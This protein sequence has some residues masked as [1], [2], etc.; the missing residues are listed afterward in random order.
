MIADFIAAESP[1]PPPS[2]SIIADYHL[3]YTEQFILYSHLRSFAKV[4]IT[5]NIYIALPRFDSMIWNTDTPQGKSNFSSMVI[6]QFLK[7][8]KRKSEHNFSTVY[9]Y[10]FFFLRG[11]F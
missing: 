9:Y 3:R 8:T 5:L 10:Y 2:L 6:L 7:Q 11:D 1:Q 4:V